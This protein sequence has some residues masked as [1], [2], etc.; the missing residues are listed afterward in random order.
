VD[1]AGFFVLD[2][3]YMPAVLIETAF[4]SNKDDEKLLKKDDFHKKTA[5][6]IF[7]S[8]VAFKEKYDVL[9][10]SSN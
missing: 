2:K 7:E 1:Q 6:A 9:K 10:A 5:K 8:I 4:I 3:A